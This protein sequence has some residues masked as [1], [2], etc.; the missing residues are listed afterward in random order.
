MLSLSSSFLC[1]FLVFNL[2][3]ADFFSAFCAPELPG[4][5]GDL[6]CL[7]Q[8]TANSEVLD[9]VRHHVL[10]TAVVVEGSRS[11]SAGVVFLN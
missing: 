4:S 10:Q 3:T 8:D 5:R 6:N 9:V 2:P 7:D 11:P 1:S